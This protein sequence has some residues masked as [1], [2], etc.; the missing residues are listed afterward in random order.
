MARYDDCEMYLEIEGATEEDIRRGLW[1][2]RNYFVA[3]EVDP[4]LAIRADE[5]VCAYMEACSAWESGEGDH[6][7][8]VPSEEDDRL[9]EI[10]SEAWR[11]ALEAAGSDRGT[12]GLV[13]NPTRSPQPAVGD[14]FS[15]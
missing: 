14:L 1:A 9:S 2:A 5:R 4:V 3:E 13:E 11:L 8:G 12:L 7:T 10:A 15:S 6:P